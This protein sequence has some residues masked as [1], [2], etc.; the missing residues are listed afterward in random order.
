VFISDALQPV[1]VLVKKEDGFYVNNIQEN[2][3]ISVA[4]SHSTEQSGGQ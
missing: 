2:D 4:G 3:T 1:C